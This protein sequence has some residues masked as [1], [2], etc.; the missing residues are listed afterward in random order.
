MRTLKAFFVILMFVPA[1]DGQTQPTASRAEIR[2]LLDFETGSD[3]GLGYRFPHV[4]I[5][6]SLERPVGKH[7][8][9]QSRVSYSPDKKYAT[10]DGNSL[11]MNWTGLVWATHRLGITGRLDHSNLWTSQFDKK[12]LAPSM[13]IVIRDDY[14]GFPGR[15]YLDYLFPT[16]C[17]WGENCRIQSNRLL[18]PEVYWEYRLWSHFRLGAKI[19][20]YRVLEQSNQLRPDIPRTGVWSGDSHLLMRYEIAPGELNQLY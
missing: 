12:S 15:L 4:A 6:L 7:F 20:V 2:W 18:G 17:Q 13:G 10:G 8:E 5:G 11:V 3:S 9:L 1:C 14:Y 16:G 19:G